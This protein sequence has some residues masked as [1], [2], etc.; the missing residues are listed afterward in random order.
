MASLGVSMIPFAPRAG[1]RVFGIVGSFGSVTL[2]PVRGGEGAR[3]MGAAAH[4]FPLPHAQGE[5]ADRRLAVPGSGP[6]S[7]HAGGGL[8]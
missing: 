5:G 6:L 2:R 7:P 8:G 3:L 1:E 4:D